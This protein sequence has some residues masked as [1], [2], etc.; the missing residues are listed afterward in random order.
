MYG[1]VFDVHTFKK[2]GARKLQAFVSREVGNSISVFCY[3]SY[4]EQRSTA[5]L[6]F[7]DQLLKLAMVDSVLSVS[8]SLCRYL[9]AA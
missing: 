6:V 3:E 4:L 8:D 7:W 2:S 9:Y 1:S 5:L